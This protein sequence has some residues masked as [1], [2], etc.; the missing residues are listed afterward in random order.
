M[1]TNVVMLLHEVVKNTPINPKL[2]ANYL[3]EIT[4]NKI[5]LQQKY[6]QNN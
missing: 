4:E 3:K 5:L 2:Y 1:K 6:T